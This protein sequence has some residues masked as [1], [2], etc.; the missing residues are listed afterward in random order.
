MIVRRGKTDLAIAVAYRNAA[1]RVAPGTSRVPRPTTGSR[2]AKG[3]EY[4]E[5]RGQNIRNPYCVAGDLGH[6]SIV[7]T[8]RYARLGEAHVRGEAARVF[9]MTSNVTPSPK[10]RKRVW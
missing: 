1:R 2:P 3:P 10:L 6:S 8:Q 4:P 9:G 7:T 5:N